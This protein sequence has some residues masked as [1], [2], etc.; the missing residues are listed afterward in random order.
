MINKLTIVLLL[1]LPVMCLALSCGDS[2]SKEKLKFLGNIKDEN[3]N[4]ISV[5][6]DLS[7][8]EVNDTKRKF[9]IRYT[10]KAESGEEQIRQIGHWE[11]DCNDRT[12]YRLSEE[13]YGPDS[14][15]L[16]KTNERVKEEYK[17]KESLGAKMAAVA[18]RYG[19]R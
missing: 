10:A 4:Y 6:M 17:S 13:Y 15:V 12:L 16:G 19:G 18:C 9:W 8:M 11:V 1:I 14:Q 3:G 5:Y 2:G 7:N